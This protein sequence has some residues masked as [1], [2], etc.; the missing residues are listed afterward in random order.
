VV[1]VIVKIYFPV[2]PAAVSF[3]VVSLKCNT[4]SLVYTNHEPIYAAVLERHS[5]QQYWHGANVCLSGPAKCRKATFSSN[6][7]I[8]LSAWNNVSRFGR[9]IIKI[10]FSTFLKFIGKFKFHLNLRG[11]TGTLHE[12]LLNEVILL[13]IDSIYSLYYIHIFQSTQLCNKSVGYSDMFRLKNS[14][15]G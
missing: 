1:H 9:T 10:N 4:A 8:G 13:G 11:I 14:S 15:S 6:V 5:F 7:S 12:Y 3:K 2:F